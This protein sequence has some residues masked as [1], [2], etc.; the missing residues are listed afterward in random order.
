MGLRDYPLSLLFVVVPVLFAAAEIGYRVARRHGG[1]DPTTHEQFAT[2]RDQAGVLLSLLLGFTLALAMGRYD[3]RMQ[4]IVEEADAVS[5]AEL[6]ADLL[7]EPQRSEARRL[8]KDYIGSR[9][10]FSKVGFDEDALVQ[11]RAK[12]GKI[13]QQLWA[14]ATAAAEKNPTPITALYAASVN[15]AID[16]D[17]R[18]LASLENR[19]PRTIWFMLGVLA[20]FA[21][22]MS[23]LSMR[24]RSI[25][26]ML[27]PALMFAIVA[28]LVADLDTPGKGLIHADTRAIARLQQGL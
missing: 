18:R 22:L 3:L 13:E 14:Q 9:V 27:L 28:L 11:A 21:S 4:Q 26:A 15:D 10:E 23:G 20:I 12:S 25:T 2:T 1:L 17:D 7:P 8:F 19:I 24:K 16:A 5:T 6:R